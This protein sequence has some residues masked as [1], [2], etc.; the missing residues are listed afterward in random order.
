MVIAGK[1][2]NGDERRYKVTKAG[3]DYAKVQKIVNDM[4]KK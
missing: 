3:Y 2:G 4:L 1:F